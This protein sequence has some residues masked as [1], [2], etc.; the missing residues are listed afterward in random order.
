MTPIGGKR[1]GAGRPKGVPNRIT[2]EIRDAAAPYSAKALKALVRV[3]DSKESSDSAVVAAATTILAYAHG[4]PRQM[5]E[6][7]GEGGGPVEIKVT[8]TIVRPVAASG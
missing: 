6:H 3:M 1:P 7:A 8:R 4:K 2:R 5:I